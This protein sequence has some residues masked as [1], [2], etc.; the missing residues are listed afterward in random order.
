MGRNEH[1]LT[2][3]IS[4]CIL[5]IQK[6]AFF[7]YVLCY[8]WI[9]QKIKVWMEHLCRFWLL[10]Q[11]AANKRVLN[12]SFNKGAGVV[13]RIEH[14][15]WSHAE[16]KMNKWLINY[17]Y[18]WKSVWTRE[19]YAVEALSFI[20]SVMEWTCRASDSLPPSKTLSSRCFTCICIIKTWIC[21]ALTLST[22]HTHSLY[23]ARMCAAVKCVSLGIRVIDRSGTD[24]ISRWSTLLL[25]LYL[26]MLN[27]H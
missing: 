27:S 15:T 9:G 18:G 12:R 1:K 23:L 13:V 19:S 14:L 16:C 3:S 6:Q 10:V 4:C 25:H 2:F 7:T 24:R 8:F 22:C 5:N 20:L 17:T 11:C 21:I 26:I